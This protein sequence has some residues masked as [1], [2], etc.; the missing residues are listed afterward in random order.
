[1]PAIAINNESDE[2]LGFLLISGDEPLR[3]DVLERE[4]ILMS[5][6]GK[7]ELLDSPASIV[8]M[9]Q[10]NIEFTLQIQQSGNDVRLFVELGVGWSLHI[11]LGVNNSGEWKLS[12]S[13][14]ETISG[15]CCLARNEE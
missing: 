1:M 12:N 9:S 13:S 8:F 2:L 5:L 7:S 15:S 10:R 6:P 14:G 11:S 3:S 4:C